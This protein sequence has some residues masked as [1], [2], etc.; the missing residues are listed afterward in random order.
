M[1]NSIFVLM[2]RKDD[3]SLESQTTTKQN[4]AGSERITGFPMEQ[5]TQ[6][7]Y[8]RSMIAIACDCFICRSVFFSCINFQKQNYEISV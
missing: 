8:N 1:W 2:Y 6:A 4:I 5:N 3:M 7:I